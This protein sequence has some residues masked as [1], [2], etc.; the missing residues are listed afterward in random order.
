[1]KK[2]ISININGIV[3]HIEED[4][5]KDLQ[6]YLDSINHYFSTY[7]EN[8][9][10]ISD[11]ESRIAELLMERL[12]NGRQVVSAEDV[13]QL[14]A[15]MGNTSDFEAI[16][17]ET[18][19]ARGEQAES[20][21]NTSS[22]RKPE[23]RKLFR[24]LN[25]R[26][27]GGVCSGLAHYIKIDPL[28]V[29]IFFLLFLSTGISLIA[30]FI[31]CIVVPGSEELTE[32]G[33]VKKFYR[34]P[35]D[36][37]LGG[38]CAGLAKYLNIDVIMIRV[39]FITLFMGGS[40]IGFLGFIPIIGLGFGFIPY[41]ILWVITREASSITDRMQMKGEKVTLSNIDENIKKK[42]NEKGFGPKREGS[43]TK[44]ILFPFR[45]IGKIL[46]GISKALAPLMLFIVFII[47]IFTGAIIALVGL[48]SMFMLVVA[49]GVALGLYNGK[50][51]HYP[52]YYIPFEFLNETISLTGL[53]AFIIVI[54]IPFLYLFIAGITV[55]AKR[56]IVSSIFNWSALGMW[57]IALLL[58]AATIPAAM[59]GFRKQSSIIRTENIAVNGQTLVLDMD[60]QYDDYRRNGFFIIDLDLRVA[61]DDQVKLKSLVRAF[62]H[63]QRDA[64]EN[65]DRVDYRYTVRDSVIVFGGMFRLESHSAYRAQRLEMTLYIPKGQPF[66]VKRGMEELL[67]HFG[68]PYHWSTVYG[69][70]AIYRNTWVF[71]ERGLECLTCDMKDRR[72]K[73]KN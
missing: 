39:L 20:G 62:G 14:V 70:S 42:Q 41:F 22:S 28:W 50:E 21:K 18:D 6:Q 59:I 7:E 47:R 30:Y 15:T 23:S 61:D 26:I 48:A 72:Q 1:M 46:S 12:T 38:V 36:R 56:K 40:F 52:G 58:A 9:E 8:K 53:I 45:L 13:A 16:E 64:E 57:L 2:N 11:I 29:R 5:Y 35:D 25:N 65:A 10:I 24:D 66:K 33:S 67:G 37:V 34:D 60:N 71:T 31:L 32:N 3:F 69:W 73:V 63:D 43:F 19:F 68:R 54:F 49:A 27:L 51:W 4:A 17:E 44:V 55:I